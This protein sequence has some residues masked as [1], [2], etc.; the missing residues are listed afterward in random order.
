MLV[1]GLTGPSGAGKST[2][3]ELLAAQGLPI[4]DADAIY[5]ELLM[6]PSDCL[7]ELSLCFGAEILLPDGTLNRRALSER[8]FS[9]PA[10]REKL[11]AIAH[12]YVMDEI[13][14]RLRKLRAT[15]VPA[16]VLDAPQLFEAGAD[17][18]CNII[19]SVLAD[20]SIRLERVMER[21]RIPAEA[22]LKRLRAQHT[23]EFFRSRSDYVIENNTNPEALIEPV[24]SILRETGVLPA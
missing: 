3:C 19:I 23:D 22:A 21:D 11:N 14:A 15:N 24:L 10:E 13:R 17:R 2:V 7:T 5:R 6:P 20:P 18:D 8:V 16:A 4:L 9:D 1:I 12:R